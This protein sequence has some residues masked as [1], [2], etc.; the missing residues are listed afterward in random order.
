MSS[1]IHQIQKTTPRQTVQ[2]TFPTGDILEGAIGTTLEAFLQT[3]LE[4]ANYCYR[5]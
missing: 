4:H 5:Y 2:I 3:A 1:V